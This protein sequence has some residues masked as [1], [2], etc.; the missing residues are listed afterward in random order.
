FNAWCSMTEE[1]NHFL[2]RSE[3]LTLAELLVVIAIIGI[4]ALASMPVFKNFQPSLQLRSAARDLISD[5]RHVQQLSIT[6][7]L[8]Y[9][10]KILPIEK[11]YQIFQCGEAEITEE[12]SFPEKIKTVTVSGFT[13]DEVSYNPYGAV[14]EEGSILLENSRGE[15]KTV[16]VKISGFVKVSD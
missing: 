5:L 14:A 1:R 8:E 6:E 10:L 15:T 11:K 3:G 12:K 2:E 7:Q 4:L 9:C 13:G 16:L